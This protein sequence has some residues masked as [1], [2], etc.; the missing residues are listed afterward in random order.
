M[1]SKDFLEEL[2][3][4]DKYSKIGLLL[5]ELPQKIQ[6]EV[7]KSVLEDSSLDYRKRYEISSYLLFAS[8]LSQ[9]D[10]KYIC[11]L[12]SRLLKPLLLT[13]HREHNNCSQ[14]E[15]KKMTKMSFSQLIFLESL[16]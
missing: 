14:L 3:K 1:E 7:I 15:Y 2:K 8:N 4:L 11:N 5:K 9:S 10:K 16:D 6:I 13:Y 12:R